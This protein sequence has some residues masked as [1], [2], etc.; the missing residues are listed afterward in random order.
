MKFPR[1]SCPT[2]VESVAVPTTHTAAVRM[3][4]TITGSARGSST[5]ASCCRSVIPTPRAASITAG[6]TPSIP[7]T[8]L[9]RIGSVL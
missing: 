4:A 8:V 5:R 6:S 7:A 9:R 2:G 1:L 3:P